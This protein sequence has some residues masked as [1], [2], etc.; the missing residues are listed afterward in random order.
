MA[1]AGDEAVAATVAGFRRGAEAERLR[2]VARDYLLGLVDVGLPL[3]EHVVTDQRNL[4][5]P[6][7]RRGDS[8]L[9]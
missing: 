2:S 5:Y 3:L 9:L 8:L 6:L 1:W 7:R 4:A